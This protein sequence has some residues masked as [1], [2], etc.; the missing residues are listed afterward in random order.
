MV[1]DPTNERRRT[2]QLPETWLAYANWKQL[3]HRKEIESLFFFTDI[4]KCNGKKNIKLLSEVSKHNNTKKMDRGLLLLLMWTVD[5]GETPEMK[6]WINSAANITHFMHCIKNACDN[7]G[8]ERLPRYFHAMIIIDKCYR[9]KCDIPFLP[10]TSRSRAYDAMFIM[11]KLN[12]LCVLDRFSARFQNERL[13][14][15]IV[16]DLIS[17]VCSF[18]SD[19]SR[20]GGAFSTYFTIILPMCEDYKSRK[21]S[22]NHCRNRRARWMWI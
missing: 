5:L 6:L 14:L 7:E 19:I 9:I 3:K 17:F 22:S 15:Y 18:A 21:K 10:N 13:H 4:N 16:C 2:K 1:F 12:C 11:K 8:R 20:G